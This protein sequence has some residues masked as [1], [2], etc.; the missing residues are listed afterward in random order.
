MRGDSRAGGQL[1]GDSL[2]AQPKISAVENF[3]QA[4]FPAEDGGGAARVAAPR[5]WGVKLGTYLNGYERRALS[6][7]AERPPSERR[8]VPDALLVAVRLATVTAYSGPQPS[9]PPVPQAP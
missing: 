2:C 8:R 6:V 1:G 7:A 3:G 4:K 5:T 9:T